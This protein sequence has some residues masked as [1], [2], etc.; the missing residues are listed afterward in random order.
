MAPHAKI[1]GWKWE[2]DGSLEDLMTIARKQ[3]RDCQTDA[4]VLNGPAYGV[5]HLLVPI[6]GEA[7]PCANSDEL[8]EAL[9]AF[10]K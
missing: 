9:V 4:C 1:V 7:V 6:R 10:L 5:G 2:A 3:I 8:G